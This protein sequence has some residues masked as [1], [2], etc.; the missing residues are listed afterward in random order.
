MSQIEIAK[1]TFEQEDL[2]TVY[3]AKWRAI[4]L[5]TE[6]IDHQKAEEAVKAAYEYI[7]K[8]EP[9]FIFFENPYRALKAII[10]ELK[11]QLGNPLGENILDELHCDTYYLSKFGRPGVWG[12]GDTIY[13]EIV[14]Q[15]G[16]ELDT[17][18]SV[19][20]HTFDPYGHKI[21]PYDIEPIR[22]ESWW[23]D[24]SWSDF[25]IS[26]KKETYWQRESTIPLSLFKYCGWIF[27]FESICII[28][29]RPSQLS[30]DGE[31]RLHAEGEPAIQ[32][33][34]G[35]SLYSY[36][37]V[38]LP[39]KYG[40]LHPEQWQ[41]QWLIEEDNAELR[42]VLI[43][44]IGY[45]RI[46]QELQATELDSWQEYTLI[47]VDADIDG[48]NYSDF[49]AID[50]SFQ[51]EP[52]YLLKMTCPST[53][54]VHAMRVPP[55]MQSAREAIRWVNWGINSEEFSVQT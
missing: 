6:P 44:G 7:N 48:V 4:A 3:E 9:K 36:H 42:R 46:C 23:G 35:Y 1:L 53:E 24:A 39:E 34:D 38:T 25:C 45:S 28:C 31:A 2:F 51:R 49:E 30:L 19:L 5:S 29:N 14:H 11:E 22:P 20:D 13:D 52:I 32:F 17:R 8:N 15:L 40:R 55:D 16:K 37:G 43:Q 27:P 47:R 21:N 50:D 10:T 41:A 12:E 18:F 26:V 33:A 54:F